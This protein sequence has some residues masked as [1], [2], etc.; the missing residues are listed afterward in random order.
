MNAILFSVPVYVGLVLLLLSFSK[1]E[2]FKQFRIY[3]KHGLYL[4]F[5]PLLGAGFFNS[6]VLKGIFA[7]PRP[8]EYVN[9]GVFYYPFQIAQAYWGQFDMSF[10]SGHVSMAAVFMVF[11]FVVHPVNATWKRYIQ[12]IL[13]IYVPIWAVVSMIISRV[14]FGDHFVSDG[15]FAVL[16]VYLICFGAAKAMKIDTINASLEKADN[17]SIIVKHDWVVVLGS[18]IIPLII[19]L[20]F[21]SRFN[22]LTTIT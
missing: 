4:A 6:V 17:G 13:G 12:V 1:R 8:H 5:V 21:L 3:R 15:I 11:Y 20:Y 22:G 2:S 18:L 9:E 14:S 19:I 10:P 7:R 16:F